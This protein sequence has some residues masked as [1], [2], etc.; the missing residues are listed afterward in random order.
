LRALVAVYATGH[1]LGHAA[2]LGLVVEELARREP[3]IRL[4]LRGHVPEF[5]FP[6][7]PGLA[8]SEIEVDF[9]VRQP[10]GLAI[11]HAATLADLAG[12]AARFDE[13]VDA[14]VGWLRAVG[15]ALVLGDVPPLAFAAAA[16]AGLPSLALANFSWD[17]IYRELARERPAYAPFAD[18]AARAYASAPCLRLPFH[19]DLGAFREIVDVPF[20]VDRSAATREEAKR[21]FELPLDRPAVLLTFG[22]FAFPEG[23]QRRLAESGDITFVVTAPPSRTVPGVRAIPPRREFGALLRAVDVVVTKPGWGVFA[24]CVANGTRILYADR[25]GFPESRILAESLERTGTAMRVAEEKVVA[26]D[27]DV[28]L[29]TLLARPVAD[30]AARSDGAAVVADHVLEGLEKVRG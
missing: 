25:A 27:I 21:R 15:A 9:G 13:R 19:G 4:A 8:R 30:D 26:G 11:D 16:K 7:R 20:V 24:G 6:D 10:D 1:G 22:G 18:L 17:W 29:R 5:L 3:G 12:L 2:R 14:E 23:A 28:E